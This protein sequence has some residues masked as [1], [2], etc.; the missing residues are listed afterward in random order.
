MDRRR[1]Y[2]W[3]D[4]LQCVFA[5]VGTA[6]GDR[7]LVPEMLASIPPDR[8]RVVAGHWL[9]IRYVTGK[10]AGPRIGHYI[11]TLQ[12]PR[13]DACWRFRPIELEHLARSVTQSLAGSHGPAG[14]YEVGVEVW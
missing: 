7:R 2:Y 5:A 1:I 4:Y 6:M 14:R 12:G 8:G 3:P 9:D 10:R 11:L 13:I